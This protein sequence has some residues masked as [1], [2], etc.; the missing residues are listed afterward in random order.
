MV[1]YNFTVE[2]FAAGILSPEIHGRVDFIKTPL[3]LE[4]GTNALIEPTGALSN[5][6]GT[7][8]LN[9]AKY[10]NRKCV[11]I[12]FVFNIAQSYAIEFGHQ[13][14]RFYRDGALLVDGSS[15][16]IEV[17]TTYQ[18]SELAEVRYTQ[19]ADVL[20]LV[21][22]NH[23]VRKLVRVSD[24]SWTL[25]N[26][27]FQPT[28]LQVQSLAL[29]K[30]GTVTVPFDWS[31][32][33]TSVNST[34]GEGMPVNAVTLSA[35]VDLG[36]TPI[37]VAFNKPSSVTGISK[38]FIY[39]KKGSYFYLVGIVNETGAASYTFKDT[40]LTADETQCPPEPFTDFGSAGNY[41]R[42]VG[43]Y[44]Q[45]LVLGGTDN[46]P[47]T[48]WLSRVGEFENFTTTPLLGDDE[49]YKRQLN[50][51]Q[52]NRI[53]HFVTLDDLLV[54][55][56]GRVWRIK[57]NTRSDLVAYVESNIG[58]SSVRPISTRKSILFLE[59]NQN[60]VSDFA[61]SDGV[62]GYDGDTL[63]KLARTLFDGYSLK[64]M[65]YQN[66]PHGIIY[67]PRS[68]GKMPVM[69]YLK[70]QNIYAWMM[71]ETDGE[72]EA[73]ASLP[74]AVSDETYMCVKRTIDGVDYRYIELVMPQI[75]ALD[76]VKD[77][78]Y[79]DCGLQYDGIA[80]DTV[81]GL[82]HLEGKTVVALA[83]GNVIKDL[84]VT[85]GSVSLGGDYE[86]V[87]V[88]LPY[89][90]KVKTINIDI[91]N[92]KLGSTIGISRFVKKFVVSIYRSR[93]LWYQSASDPVIYEHVTTETTAIGDAIPL[94]S[95]KLKIDA[96]GSSE[97]ENQI[98][99][100]QYDPLPVKILNITHELDIGEAL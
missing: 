8:F 12:D 68:D 26:A 2:A 7:K 96:A 100:Y 15:V 58:I 81:S 32:T 25:S 60:T 94:E 67:C 37:T 53:S 47:N 24:T 20:Y 59:A 1:D 69:T 92:T 48:I 91:T 87:T 42:S 85:S 78:W 51:G 95:G 56:D 14:M 4:E 86:K 6:P 65:S 40:G 73:V 33:V 41:P 71:Y 55:T 84:V 80:V 45:R 30:T 10:S 89:T 35:D 21:H 82:N 76:D 3:G 9:A 46:E 38:Y 22:P 70:N 90:M 31:Y 19:S 11:F 54:F 49:G 17:T 27:S 43:I 57:G 79:V 50:S 62:A 44:N 52:V 63:D 88:G 23:P 83:D 18:E 99:L 28:V 74:K 93:G 75:G 66:N 64:D 98:I 36:T 13:Y 16:P 61:Y 39:R 34:G 72:I 29:S 97:R 77:S 5:R